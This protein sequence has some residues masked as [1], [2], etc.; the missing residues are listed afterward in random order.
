MNYWSHRASKLLNQG[1]KLLL[2]QASGALSTD[3]LQILVCCVLTRPI[4]SYLLG[5][6]EGTWWDWWHPSHSPWI[7]LS[8]GFPPATHAQRHR[9]TRWPQS[10]QV[11]DVRMKVPR[12]CGQQV[13][14]PVDAGPGDYIPSKWRAWRSPCELSKVDTAGWEPG[15]M[16]GDGSDSEHLQALNEFTFTRMLW[17]SDGLEESCKPIPTSIYETGSD[18][19]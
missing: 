14:G 12:Y 16:V 5:C 7:H 17:A 15:D 13:W 4:L 8:A 10:L 11:C 2:S 1:W 9:A 19:H 18:F 6:T 3:P